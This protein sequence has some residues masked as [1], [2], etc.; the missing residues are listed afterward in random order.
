MIGIEFHVD[1]D[2]DSV[3]VYDGPG[4]EGEMIAN[5]CG[6]NSPSLM[7]IDSRNAMIEFKSD[8]TVTGPGFEVYYL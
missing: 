8:D 2:W 3:R 5:L 7:T 6:K 4:E 1:C